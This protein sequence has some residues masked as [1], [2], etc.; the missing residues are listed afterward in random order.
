MFIKNQIIVKLF[1]T[2]V[3]VGK[4]SDYNLCYAYRLTDAA[5]AIWKF[6]LYG[7]N[8]QQK[9]LKEDVKGEE[10]DANNGVQKR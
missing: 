9:I 4:Y 2:C 8:P 1:D 3:A 6:Y 7:I 10:I 5:P